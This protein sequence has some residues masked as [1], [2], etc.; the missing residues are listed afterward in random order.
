MMKSLRKFLE[1]AFLQTIGVMGFSAYANLAFGFNILSV[2][3]WRYFMDMQLDGQAIAGGFYIAMLFFAVYSVA[4]VWFALVRPRRR[5]RFA[6]ANAPA[7]NYMPLLVASPAAS[8]VLDI[9]PVEISAA[10]TALE[11]PRRMAPLAQPMYRPATPPAVPT[12]QPVLSPTPAPANTDEEI[13][14]NAAP[15]VLR[16][17]ESAGFT[18]GK[19]PK[20]EGVQLDVWALNGEELYIGIV[21]G[22]HG[23][24]MAHEGGK[25]IWSSDIDG[26]FKSPVSE[27]YSA[28][29]AL[30]ALFAETLDAGMQIK[31]VPFVVMADGNI[32][33]YEKLSSIWAALGVK[34][35]NHGVPELTAFA[36]EIEKLPKNE[37]FVEYM[38]TILWYYGGDKK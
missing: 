17:L 8:P 32:E 27:I 13:K 6:K 33:N 4:V 24:V 3:H 1:F 36:R 10:A 12:Y 30:Q 19:A 9:K 25:N 18:I 11:R 23:R 29:E 7:D 38:D 16:E 20:I 21:C 22:A 26:G 31:I 37:S 34:V 2:A 15:E 28:V 14:S 5:I 35:M